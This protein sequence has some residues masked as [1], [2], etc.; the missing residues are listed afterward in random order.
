VVEVSRGLEDAVELD[1]VLAVAP[2]VLDEV[3]LPTGLPLTV[4]LGLETADDCEPD[5]F[6]ALLFDPEVEVWA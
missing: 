2:E 1:R 4:T 5:E 6:V 3:L